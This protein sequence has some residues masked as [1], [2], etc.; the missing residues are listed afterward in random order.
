MKTIQE[1][2]NEIVESVKAAGIDFE[3]GKWNYSDGTSSFIQLADNNFKIIKTKDRWDEYEGYA[4]IVEVVDRHNGTSE[5]KSVRISV[6]SLKGCCGYREYSAK[7][8]NRFSDKKAQK[9]IAD[10]IQ[11]YKNLSQTLDKTKKV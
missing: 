11:K 4:I 9:I 10:T 5:N 3:I 7:I 1:L 8:Y 6:E 2:F